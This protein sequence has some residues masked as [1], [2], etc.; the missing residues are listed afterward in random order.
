[1]VLCVSMGAIAMLLKGLGFDKWYL[2]KSSPDEISL[3][4]GIGVL[5]SGNQLG[6]QLNGSEQIAIAIRL[7]H[8]NG[9]FHISDHK[10]TTIRELETYIANNWTSFISIYVYDDP[11]KY[12]W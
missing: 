8:S 11:R 4:G 2:I 5:Y 9:C 12:M 10:C 6:D 7:D 3:F 1:M